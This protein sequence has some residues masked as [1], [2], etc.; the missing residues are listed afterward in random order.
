MGARL[1]AA[2]DAGDLPLVNSLLAE[3]SD[4]DLLHG[5]AEGKT[6]LMAAAEAGHEQV[7]LAL[8]QGGCPW[9]QQCASGY[10]AGEYA[11]RRPDITEM[12]MEWGV[13]AELAAL[14]AA[15][16]CGVLCFVCGG[17]AVWAPLPAARCLGPEHRRRVLVACL[18]W[19]KWAPTV[20]HPAARTH[21]HRALRCMA[22]CVAHNRADGTPSAST[23]AS[24]PPASTE[25][26]DYLQQRLHY[27]PDGDKLL[28]ANGE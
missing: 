20:S 17:V 23:S 19:Q 24:G 10:C 16:R 28:D 27:T 13:Q 18:L 4:A 22:C 9:N 25:N 8:L 6:A 12:V 14:E 2:A 15:D 21:A 11:A 1:L 7:V 3:A 26:R 5:D